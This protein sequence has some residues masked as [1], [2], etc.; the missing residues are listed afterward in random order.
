M[1]SPDKDK[2]ILSNQNAV[3]LLVYLY[4]KGGAAKASHILEAVSN[5]NSIKNVG[6]RLEEVGLIKISENTEVDQG[7]KR[8]YILYELTE[9]GREVA[10]HLKR[11][12]DALRGLCVEEDYIPA[13]GRSVSD[14]VKADKE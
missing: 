9:E 2:S 1:K 12:E 13:S 6:A 7:K 14:S 10:K 5:Y 3:P 8:Y 4:E 11:A